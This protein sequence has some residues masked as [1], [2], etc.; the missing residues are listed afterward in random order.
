MHHT[1]TFYSLMSAACHIG[2]RESERKRSRK[3]GRKRPREGGGGGVT[4]G[5]SYAHSEA[6]LLQPPPFL[7]HPPLPLVS[8][9]THKHSELRFSTADEKSLATPLVSFALPDRRERRGGR[10]NIISVAV[11]AYTSDWAPNYRW[12]PHTAAPAFNLQ[13]S[14]QHEERRYALCISFPLCSQRGASPWLEL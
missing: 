9:P 11:S 7:S 13:Y 6:Q 2:G 10:A 8:P 14:F 3:K 1:T 4:Q 5:V 12:T